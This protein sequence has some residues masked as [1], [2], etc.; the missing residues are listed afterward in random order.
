MKILVAGTGF[1]GSKVKEELEHE[2]QVKTLDRSEGDFQQDITEKFDIDED[3]DV[4]FH[5]IGLAPGMKNKRLYK[6]VHVK[7]TRNL[8][9][10]VDSNK[11]VYLSALGVGKVNHSFFQ[12]KEKSEEIIKN[13][14]RDY[15]IIRPSTVYGDGNKLLEM[16][17]TAAPSRIFPDLKTETQPIHIDDL[18][19]ILRKSAKDFR[20]ETL[21]VGGP[22]K[23]TVGQLAK[24]LYREEGFRCILLPIPEIMQTTALKLTPLS[25]PFSTENIELLKQQNTTDKNDAERILGSLKKV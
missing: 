8:L 23:I 7:G 4:L 14:E 17:K 22:E 13:S 21:E 10:A 3:F 5:T 18:G 2:H 6:E 11:V 12:T 24:K 1:I 19:E 15:T 25:G 16:I 9:D 20:N